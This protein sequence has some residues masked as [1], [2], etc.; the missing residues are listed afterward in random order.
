MRALCG[1]IDIFDEYLRALSASEECR[2]DVMWK[3]IL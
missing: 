3:L 1:E 2:E